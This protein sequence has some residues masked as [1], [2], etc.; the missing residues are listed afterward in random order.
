MYVLC[1]GSSTMCSP[2][3]ITPCAGMGCNRGIFFGFYPTTALTLHHTL[4]SRD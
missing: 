2:G 4:K 3:L 1:T